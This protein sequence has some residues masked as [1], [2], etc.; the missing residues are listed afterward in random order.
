ML[1][2]E[3]I[4]VFECIIKKSRFIAETL[5]VETPEEA[6]EHLKKKRLEHP[7]AAHVVHAFITGEQRQFMGMSDDGEPSGTSGKPVLEILKGRGI[8]NIMLTVVRYFGGTKLGTGGLVRAY[9]E[10]AVGA[11]DRLKT[12]ELVKYSAFSVSADYHFYQGIKMLLEEYGCRI[13]DESFGTGVEIKGAVPQDNEQPLVNAVKDLSSGQV[14]LDLSG[15][16]SQV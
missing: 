6:R 7:D 14:L 4:S 16:I 1:I 12:V 15:N 3:G 2:P 5:P 13:D 9:S 10:S 11:L 8:T